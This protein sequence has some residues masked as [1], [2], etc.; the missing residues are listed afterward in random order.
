M[1]ELERRNAKFEKKEEEEDFKFTNKGCEKQFKFNG[2]V[3]EVLC[4]RLKVEL[5]KH[6]K[7]GLPGKV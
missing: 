3:K 7:G 1:E 2:K 4:D 6:F 5:K